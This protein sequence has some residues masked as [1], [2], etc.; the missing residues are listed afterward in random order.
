MKKQILM[1]LL[2]LFTLSTVDASAQNFLKKMGKAVEKEVKDKVEKEID[3]RVKKPAKQKMQEA[4]G[5]TQSATKSSKSKQQDAPV[6]DPIMA[7]GPLKG[8]VGTHEWVDMG[9]PSGLKWATCNLGADAP[10]RNGHFYEWGEVSQFLDKEA[11]KNE[12]DSK[13]M[14]DISGNPKYDAARKVWGSTWRIPTQAEFEELM[15][16]CTI[17]YTQLA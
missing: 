3:K 14:G 15:D 11:A 12:I 2:L 1:A 9:L 4:Q 7:R 17:E 6:I 16:N 8:K 13:K 10:D 5:N